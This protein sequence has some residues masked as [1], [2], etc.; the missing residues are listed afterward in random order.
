MVNEV[1]KFTVLINSQLKSVLVLYTDNIHRKLALLH[2]HLRVLWLDADTLS[3]LRILDEC[4][5]NVPA[6]KL[7]Q[8]LNLTEEAV[9][10]QCIIELLY[11][12]LIN[13]C[14][15]KC[16]ESMPKIRELGSLYYRMVSHSVLLSVRFW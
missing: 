5:T 3:L 10:I 12:C 7:P 14:K 4:A 15:D 9:V 11:I 1:A 8:N 6:D 2:Y 16:T 13:S